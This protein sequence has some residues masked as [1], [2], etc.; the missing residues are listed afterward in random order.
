MQLLMEI[1]PLQVIDGNLSTSTSHSIHLLMENCPIRN[2][3]FTVI[4][5][6]IDGN[7]TTFHSIHLLMENYSLQFVAVTDI[8]VVSMEN[9]RL[10][11]N[12]FTLIHVVADGNISTPV[13]NSPILLKH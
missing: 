4:H 10:Q 12:L 8:T 5:V 3:P 9:Y 1:Y 6:V 2:N 7:L 13:V 11:T